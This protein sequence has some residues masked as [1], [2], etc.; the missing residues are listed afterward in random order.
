MLATTT[1]TTNTNDTTTT[2][3]TNANDTAQPQQRPKKK[4]ERKPKWM[5][6]PTPFD[7]QRCARLILEAARLLR[8]R[9]VV[10]VGSSGAA[11]EAVRGLDS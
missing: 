5:C 8:P 2:T 7:K 11:A 4:E 9:R 10:V 3:T 6:A 1:T